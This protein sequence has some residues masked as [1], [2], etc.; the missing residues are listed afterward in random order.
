MKKEAPITFLV[1]KSR[2][3]SLAEECPEYKHA[4]E[5]LFPEVFEEEVE[6]FQFQVGDIIEGLCNK[7]TSSSKRTGTA[8]GIIKVIHSQMRLSI[9]VEFFYNMK[10][11]SLGMENPA[12]SGHGWWHANEDVTLVFRPRDDKKVKEK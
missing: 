11:H 12:V 4:M 3:K 10:G 9:G 8:L 1:E 6:D 5:V 2:I 7:H